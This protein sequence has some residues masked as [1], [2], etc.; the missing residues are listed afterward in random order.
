MIIK[1]L[2]EDTGLDSFG[3]NES[4]RSGTYEETFMF[5]F[6]FFLII[7]LIMLNIINGIIIDA[8][9]VLRDK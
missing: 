5:D 2:R 4:F 9:A 1:G 6:S 7:T 3:Y 8:F